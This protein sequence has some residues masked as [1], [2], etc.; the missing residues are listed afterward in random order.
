MHFVECQP[1]AYAINHATA[2][3]GRE[4]VKVLMALLDEE[5]LVPP[6]GNKAD[7]LSEDLAVLTGA[8]ETCMLTLF[9]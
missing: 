2:L 8:E 3:G 4:T 1:K 7:L 9:R 6:C 5:A